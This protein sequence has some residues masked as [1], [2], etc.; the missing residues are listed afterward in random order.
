MKYSHT[1]RFSIPTTAGEL[2][3]ALRQVP[4]EARLN[5]S[6]TPGDRPWEGS[7]EIIIATWTTEA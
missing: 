2:I 1:T 7:T 3:W 6:V 5:V 4:V